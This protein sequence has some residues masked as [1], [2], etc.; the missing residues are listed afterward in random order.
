VVTG[1]ADSGPGTLRHCLG[2]AVAG[3]TIIFDVGVFPPTS[4]TIISLSSELPW[5][6]VDDLTIDA[7]DA[8]VILDGSGLS[9]GYGFVVWGAD[10]VKIRGLQI[11]QFPQHGVAIAGGATNTVIGGDR[12][13]GNG[14]LGQGNLINGNGQLGVW[15]EGSGTTS[16]TVH[17]NF[18][19]G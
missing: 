14:P 7:S 3:D 6:T 19:L 11:V 16:N 5:I 15:L 2:N 10:G 17:G 18:A 12:F 4:P 1:T 9:S 8:G 13:T